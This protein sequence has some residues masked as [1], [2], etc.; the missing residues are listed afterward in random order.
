MFTLFYP[1]GYLTIRNPEY[2]D[3]RRLD[4]NVENRP[5]VG[6]EYKTVDDW[7]DKQFRVF[8]FRSLRRAQMVTFRSALQA[9]A[10][11]QVTISDSNDELWDGY[12]ISNPSDIVTIKDDCNYD[13]DFE[14]MA[15]YSGVA[16]LLLNDVGAQVYNGDEDTVKVI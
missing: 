7:P 10:G 14:M 4:T 12:I 8:T 11:L 16:Q 5:T 2:G 3:I 15:I 1:G 6:G 13:V 9:A